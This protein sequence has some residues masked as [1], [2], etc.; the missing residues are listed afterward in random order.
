MSFDYGSGIRGQKYWANMEER[1]IW[2]QVD[3]E[4]RWVH[5]VLECNES[6]L[7]TNLNNKKIKVAKRPQTSY[8]TGT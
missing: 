3:K 7:Y 1:G 8:L 4:W 6:T 2:T 5:W